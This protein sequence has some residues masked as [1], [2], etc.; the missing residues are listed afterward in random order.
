MKRR[1]QRGEAPQVSSSED[2]LLI[3]FLLLAIIG[4]LNGGCAGLGAFESGRVLEKGREQIMFGLSFRSVHRVQADDDALWSSLQSFPFRT[5]A[6]SLLPFEVDGLILFRRGLGSSFEGEIGATTSWLLSFL[7]A[8][9]M[10]GPSVV[11][12][13]NYG[14]VQDPTLASSLGA[15]WSIDAFFGGANRIS[16]AAL[17]VGFHLR[18]TWGLH[19]DRDVGALYIS[20][21]LHYR[22]SA[23]AD[24]RGEARRDGEPLPWSTHTASIYWLGSTL[25]GEFTPG[26]RLG[27]EAGADLAPAQ[28]GLSEPRLAPRIGVSFRPASEPAD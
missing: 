25:G 7:T 26:P 20:Q 2:R 18:T 24:R 21:G 1:L 17:M 11:L 15:R 22:W 10:H 27:L 9:H 5:F 3:M 8:G 13:I 19:N 6:P 28:A 12:G 4:S 16:V 23:F 14:L